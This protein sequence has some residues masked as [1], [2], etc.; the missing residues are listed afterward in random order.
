MYTAPIAPPATRLFRRGHRGLTTWLTVTCLG[1]GLAFGPLAALPVTAQTPAPDLFDAIASGDL[2]MV[3]AVVGKT[4]AL[5]NA[6]KVVPVAEWA[7]MKSPDP[8]EP[9]FRGKVSPLVLAVLTDH[10]DIA[11]W[12]LSKGARTDYYASFE[13]LKNPNLGLWEGSALFTAVERGDPRMVKLLLDAKADP[14]LKVRYFGG[15][16]PPKKG[17][18]GADRSLFG[19]RYFGDIRARLT[20][21]DLCL[22]PG[23]RSATLFKLIRRYAPRLKPEYY[24]DTLFHAAV[25]NDRA[26]LGRLLDAGH[27]P[28]GQTLAVLMRNGDGETL[29]NLMAHGLPGLPDTNCW[30]AAGKLMAALDNYWYEKV[31]G[32]LEKPAQF[33]QAERLEFQTRMRGLTALL[34]AINGSLEASRQLLV[35]VGYP[36]DRSGLNFAIRVLFEPWLLP[37]RV[38]GQPD[39]PGGKSPSLVA[40]GFDQ[41]VATTLFGSWTADAP[42]DWRLEFTGGSIHNTG[43]DGAGRHFE[44][45][46]AP[47]RVAVED[48]PA[49][50]EHNGWIL[51]AGDQDKPWLTLR[52]VDNALEVYDLDQKQ[53][54]RFNKAD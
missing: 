15:P 45:W 9:D 48:G 6:I 12:L 17:E 28:D 23:F 43:T 13:S 18:P 31:L 53:T 35:S 33:T 44:T 7:G 25:S 47:W 34:P 24:A 14:G 5:A 21:I 8:T 37:S 51:R 27:M 29:R 20:V 49:G 26:L 19:A 16:P 4:P 11:A 1:A 32:R 22:A 36:A 40:L 54:T 52:F 46:P 30:P 38:L 10:H 42:V 2:A 41:L 50:P 39:Q 3:K